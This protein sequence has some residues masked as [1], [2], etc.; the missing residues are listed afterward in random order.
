[1]TMLFF[2][3]KYGRFLSDGSL[4]QL[5]VCL[6]ILVVTENKQNKLS[7]V[8]EPSDNGAIWAEPTVIIWEGQ[9]IKSWKYDQCTIVCQA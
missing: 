5:F 9:A 1:M 2:L 8:I 7:Q 6:F 4:F 3:D